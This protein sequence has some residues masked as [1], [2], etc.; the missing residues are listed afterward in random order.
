[1]SVVEVADALERAP[2]QGAAVD[3]PEGARFVVISDIALSRI[4]RALRLASAERQD[5][6]FF[7][8]TR[9]ENSND[10]VSEG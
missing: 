6:E 1:M 9:K 2:R 3:K 10:H 7:T 4:I 5:A 8:S